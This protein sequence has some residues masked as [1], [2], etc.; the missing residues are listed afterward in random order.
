[1]ENLNQFGKKFVAYYR[2]STQKQG[3]SGLGLDAQKTHVKMHISSRANILFT[4]VKIGDVLL[5]EYTDIE[6]GKNQ[7]REN[8][9]MALRHAKATGATLVIAKLDRLSRNLKFICELMESKID[10]I[11][12]DMPDT[13]PLTLHIHGAIA[14]QELRMISERTKNALTQKSKQIKEAGG[15]VDRNGEFRTSLGN[16]KNFRNDGVDY[17]E[18]NRK[19][20]KRKKFLEDNKQ[21]LIFVKRMRSNSF[22]YNGNVNGGKPTYLQI[23][24]ELNALGLR[25]TTGKLFMPMQVKRLCD[26]IVKEDEK[27]ILIK[28]NFPVPEGPMA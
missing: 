21:A 17:G 5:A 20:A 28:E 6:T 2:V 16:A 25:T 22:Y 1:M 11:C 15:Y 27:K 8:L 4:D 9:N 14:E 10:F 26:F 13:T 18:K 3:V 19:I 7:N 12:C 23:A 24:N